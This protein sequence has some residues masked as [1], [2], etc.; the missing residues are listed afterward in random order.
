ME[1]IES[2][3]ESER[4]I[5]VAG[6]YFIISIVQISKQLDIHEIITRAIAS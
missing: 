5:R 4:G 2:E 6:Y 3:S 1:K